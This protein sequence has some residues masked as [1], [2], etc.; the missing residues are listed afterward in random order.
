MVSVALRRL[1]ASLWGDMLA[2]KLH[3]HGNIKSFKGHISHADLG[4]KEE[5]NINFLGAY[6]VSPVEN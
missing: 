4:I 1:S 2:T 6:C 5:R 3:K